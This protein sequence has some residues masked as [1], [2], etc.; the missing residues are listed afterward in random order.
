VFLQPSDIKGNALLNW[1][2]KNQADDQWLDLPAQGRM[3][4]CLSAITEFCKKQDCFMKGVTCPRC[5]YH[6]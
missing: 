3:Q 2:R 4:W 5:L 1:Q 6:L